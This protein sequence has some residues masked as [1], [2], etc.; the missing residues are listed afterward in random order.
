MSLDHPVADSTTDD[1]TRME[2]LPLVPLLDREP[3]GTALPAPLTT[4]VG[5]DHETAAIVSL[6][7]QEEVRLVTLTGPGGVGKTRLALQVAGELATQFRDGVIFIPLASV[8]DP[9]LVPATIAGALG[10]REAAGRSLLDRLVT[11]LS[12]RSLLLVVDNFEHL[13]AAAPLLTNLLAAA[14]RLTVLVT[15]RVVL[16]LSGECPYPVPPLALPGRETSDE[17][18]EHG[19]QSLVARLSSVDSVRLFVARAAAA[20]PGFTLDADNAAAVAEVCRRL[21]GLPLALELAAARLRVLP[22]GALL[23]RLD[24][25]LAILTGGARDQPA[26]LRTLRDAIAWSH[27]LLSPADRSLFARLAV[28]IGGFGLEGAVAVAGDSTTNELEI[29][30]GVARLVDAS[31][32][33]QEGEQA[34]GPRFGMLETIREYGRER[35]A[36]SGEEPEVRGRHAAWCLALAEQEEASIWSGADQARRLDRQAAEFANLRAALSWLDETGDADGLLRL[37]GALS[38]VWFQRGPRSEGRAW[39]TRALAMSG[40]GTTAARANGLFALGALRG[41]MGGSNAIDL[42]FESL[43]LRRNLGDERGIALALLFLGSA[44]VR[45]EDLDRAVPLLEEATARFEA[46]GNLL[47]VAFAR[48]QYGMVALASG[49]GPRAEALLI[50]ALA[51]FRQLG[52]QF[53]IAGCLV[54]MGMVLEDRGDL[55]GAAAYYAERLDLWDDYGHLEGFAD[56]LVGAGKLAVASGWLEPAGRLLGAATALADALG[57]IPSARERARR[58]RAIAAVRAALGDAAFEAAWRAGRALTPM[59]A[60]LE[61]RA[62]LAESAA[63]SQQRT[64]A[65]DHALTP[66]EL[67]I[68]RLIEAGLSNRQ[69][70][71]TLFTSERT[72]ANHNSSIFAKLSVDSRTAAVA[73][74]RQLGIL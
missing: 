64:A 13:A 38:Y 26:R 16:G 3:I 40:T 59:Q 58:E 29:L 41:T 71:E 22:P 32:V 69:I 15:S 28:F 18:R 55:A 33:R 21:D 8:A 68:L 17:R 62:V 2:P 39:L 23:D 30:D 7:C 9:D 49:N 46:L 6:L 73:R 11:F 37:A 52:Q 42:L 56:A 65:T 14:P 66:R 44:F 57:D 10:V 4:F 61:A 45:N 63:E 67:E 24:H 1:R 31:L 36:T 35:L 27:D 50:E 19:G 25:R 20:Q 34:G 54:N 48:V 12:E 53:G 43:E 60:S 51:R 74:A 5:R 72:V 70:G 47:G